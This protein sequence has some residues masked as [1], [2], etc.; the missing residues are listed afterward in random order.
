MLTMTECTRKTTCYE[1]CENCEFIDSFI[2]EERKRMTNS[3]A[4]ELLRK[5]AGCR[6]EKCGANCS[7]C[8]HNA[9]YNDVTAAINVAI[10]ALELCVMIEDDGR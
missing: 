9:P 6:N 10:E 4:L 7:M 5:E 2:E 8:E 1:D 3:E